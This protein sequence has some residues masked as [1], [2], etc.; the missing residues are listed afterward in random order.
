MGT[1]SPPTSSSDMTQI[2][3][4]SGLQM[5][6]LTHQVSMFTLTSQLKGGLYKS[7]TS[8]HEIL[9]PDPF[10]MF[11][12]RLVHLYFCFPKYITCIM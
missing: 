2:F 10:H 1:G 6:C 4:H 8:V 7:Q 12:R 3:D 11:S 9:P 5:F